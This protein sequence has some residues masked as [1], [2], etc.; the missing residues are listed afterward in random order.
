MAGAFPNFLHNPRRLDKDSRLLLNCF[1]RNKITF[2]KSADVAGIPSEIEAGELCIVK[3][4]SDSDTSLI[5]V[6]PSKNLNSARL[7]R[8][9]VT[10]L[11][12]RCD[13]VNTCDHY[14]SILLNI[15]GM[16]PRQLRGAPRTAQVI[17]V[18]ALTMS[19]LHCRRT[20]HRDLRPENTLLQWDW[21]M[22]IAGFGDNHSPRNL[23]P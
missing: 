5:A 7:I 18:I 11:A 9:E 8:R 15:P 16:D 13:P 2:P 6:K 22:P 3:I 20:I 12:L 4:A 17:A 23:L 21:L 14:S 19:F 10:I 1:Q